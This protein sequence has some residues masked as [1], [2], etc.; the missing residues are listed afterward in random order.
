MRGKAGPQVGLS[1]LSDLSN[2]T[3]ALYLQTTSARARLI[4]V[5]SPHS[6][7]RLTDCPCN[8]PIGKPDDLF[9]PA[10]VFDVYAVAFALHAC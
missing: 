3:T 8:R 6:D 5:R 10:A 7:W 9:L 4:S 2:S 1:P